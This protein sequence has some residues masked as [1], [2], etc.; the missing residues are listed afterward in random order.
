MATTSVSLDAVLSEIDS[1]VKTRRERG[2][3]PEDLEEQ[4]ASHFRRI[5]LNRPLGPDYKKLHE[6]L[7]VLERESLFS[8][9]RIS[10]DSSVPGGD[11]LHGVVAKVVSRQ[12]NGLLQQMQG[13][14]DATTSTVSDLV[15]VLEHQANHGLSDVVGQID[16]VLERLGELQRD[17]NDLRDRVARLE[18]AISEIRKSK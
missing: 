16:H 13:F 3:Y 14:A 8:A 9:S 18:S 7:N 1:R 5:V 17:N 10:L 2:D 12:T 15:D 6:A 11:K 4:L